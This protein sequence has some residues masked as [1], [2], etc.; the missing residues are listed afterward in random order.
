MCCPATEPAN[1][2]S[3]ANTSLSLQGIY[4][5]LTLSGSSLILGHIV[6]TYTRDATYRAMYAS[7]L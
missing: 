3:I 6:T 1:G 4:E 5:H 2:L 7:T